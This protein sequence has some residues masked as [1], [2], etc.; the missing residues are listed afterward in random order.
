MCAPQTF[1]QEW[2]M[3]LLLVEM[4]MLEKKERRAAWHDGTSD[5]GDVKMKGAGKESVLTIWL[6][7]VC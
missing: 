7:P 4:K 3:F 5:M 6:S 1:F 2:K